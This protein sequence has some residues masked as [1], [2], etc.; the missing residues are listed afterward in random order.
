MQTIIGLFDT[1]A[2]ARDAAR[3]LA[4]RGVP[5]NMIGLMEDGP[6]VSG[7]LLTV[8]AEAAG[9]A[10]AVAAMRRHRVADIQQRDG[11]WQVEKGWRDAEGDYSVPRANRDPSAHT[12][13]DPA[14]PRVRRDHRDEPAGAA[15]QDSSKVGTAAGALSGAAAG[16]AA[17][18]LGGPAGAVI[19]GA[20]GAAAGAAAGAAGDVAGE[21]AV[22]ADEYRGVNEYDDDTLSPPELSARRAD[23]FARDEGLFAA[24]QQAAGLGQ[25]DYAAYAPAYRFGYV[26]ASDPRYAA[27]SWETVEP[28]LRREWERDRQGS[29]GEFA[30][31]VRYAWEISRGMR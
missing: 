16:A 8:R 23:D 24:H 20:L 21:R 7:A 26:M 9:V 29:W 18:A 10:Q 2:G 19:G 12:D 11:D 3:E 27:D 5:E 31:A 14:A 1:L 4:E 28:K 17:G 6:G 15:W 22:P 30:P 25:R 13:P